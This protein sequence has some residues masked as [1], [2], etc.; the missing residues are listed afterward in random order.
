MARRMFSSDI[1]SSDAFIEMPVTSQCLYFHL[2]VRA[3]D[4]GFV[5]PNITMRM[6]NASGDDLKILIAK[7]FLLPFQNGVV[8]VKHWRINNFIRKDRY[9]ETN[10]TDEKQMLRVKENMAYTLDESQGQPIALVPWKSDREVRLSLGQPLVNAGK[11]RVGKVRVGKD[12]TQ[13][14]DVEDVEFEYDPLFVEFWSAYP[15]KI[16]KGQAYRSWQKMKPKASRILVDTII[17]SIEDHLKTDQWKKE[18]GQFIPYPS[19]FINQRGWE[20]E[21]KPSG[22]GRISKYSTVAVH[23]A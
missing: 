9:K 4:D 22:N 5:N 12:T 20:D 6:V 8:V 13:C 1:V 21:L 14:D 10:Y 11:V 7:R 15:K 16:A 3:D 18:H 19:T 2:G 23:K 17:A